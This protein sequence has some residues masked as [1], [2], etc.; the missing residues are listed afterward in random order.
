MPGEVTGEEAEPL[1]YLWHAIDADDN[2]TFIY[3]FYIDPAL[4]SQGYGK[5]AIAALE[6]SL[7]ASDI[8]QIKLRVAYDNPRAL[9]LYQEAGFIITG[10]NMAK[11]LG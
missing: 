11:L 10:H 7:R 3:D 4:R 6:A 9:A 2:A 8:S 1:G 5:A